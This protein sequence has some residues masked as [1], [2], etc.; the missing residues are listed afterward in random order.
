M[1]ENGV[2]LSGGERQHLALARAFYREPS[3]L[4]LDEATSQLDATTEH[5][6]LVDL[7]NNSPDI[8]L[9]AV[10]HRKSTADLFPRC[11]IVGDQTVSDINPQKIASIAS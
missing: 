4:V 5:S 3:F 9:I 11:W 1:G 8:T 10:T 2:A 6:F 7:F